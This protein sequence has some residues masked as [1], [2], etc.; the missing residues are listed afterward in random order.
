MRDLTIMSTV[1]IHH[2]QAPSPLGPLRLAATAQGLCGV[3][4]EGQ[5]HYP[6]TANW[7]APSDSALLQEARDQLQAYFAGQREPFSLPLDLCLGTAFAQGV[8]Q[9]LLQIA[10]GDTRSY[11]EIGR[12]LGQ[13]T[14]ARAVGAAVG[15]NPLSIIVPCHRV[16]GAQGALT[17]Y[18]GGLERKVALLSLE[19]PQKVALATG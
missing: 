14:A 15:R 16:L 2:I 19:R 3:W 1:V 11:G 4:F 17:G 6:D 7:P 5:R 8:W 13:P 18:A 9:Q 10:W 12:R